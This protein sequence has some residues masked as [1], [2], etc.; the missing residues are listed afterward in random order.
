MLIR[1]NY[2]HKNRF[3][4]FLYAPLH[5]VYD[6]AQ[7]WAITFLSGPVTDNELSYWAGG[8]KLNIET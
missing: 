4:S 7:R 8:S 6:V 3:L 1:R 5:Y 2:S